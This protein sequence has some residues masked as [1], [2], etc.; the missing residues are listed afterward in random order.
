MKLS[1]LLV[2][3]NLESAQVVQVQVVSICKIPSSR[4]SA[5]GKLK[6]ASPED[7]AS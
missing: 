6:L 2:V 7:K 1:N 3:W 5:E 4:N